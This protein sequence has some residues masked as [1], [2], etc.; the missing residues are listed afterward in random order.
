MRFEYY[1][2]INEHPIQEDVGRIII[3]ARIF[4]EEGNNLTFSTITLTHTFIYVDEKCE[5]KRDFDD[6]WAK[7]AGIDEDECDDA[8]IE[9][10][11]YVCDLNYPL[12]IEVKVDIT[13]NHHVVEREEEVYEIE[14]RDKIM[15]RPA[16]KDVV[17][18]L[19]RKI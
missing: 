13:P 18:S 4:R 1:N 5:S 10:V 16:N 9:L 12:T 17:K 19:T 11:F 8:L 6:F 14:E 3:V 7:V 15:F 2:K